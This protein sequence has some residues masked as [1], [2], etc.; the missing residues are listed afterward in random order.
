MQSTD[1]ISADLSAGNRRLETRTR[2][3]SCSFVVDFLRASVV[4][5]SVSSLRCASVAESVVFL[6]LYWKQLF[7]RIWCTRYVCEVLLVT[8]W[9]L[10]AAFLFLASA[11]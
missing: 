2:P 1:S 4:D 9:L 6:G 10:Y 8:F 3:Y 11:N 7:E 5:D